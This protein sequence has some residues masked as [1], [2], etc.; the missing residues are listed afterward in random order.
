MLGL[1][2]SHVMCLAL[3]FVALAL[4]DRNSLHSMHETNSSVRFFQLQ[5]MAGEGSLSI[6]SSLCR[7]S[8]RPT[9]LDLAV[10][11]DGRPYPNKAP[12]LQMLALPVFAGMASFFPEDFM[13]M[14]WTLTVLALV[15]GLIPLLFAS[16]LWMRLFVRARDSKKRH[17]FSRFC[18]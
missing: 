14:H 16:T 15:F 10:G 5:A 9:T 3:C 18:C 4:P 8:P 12:G 1:N 17:T 6:E 11:L 7:W 13:P 2:K